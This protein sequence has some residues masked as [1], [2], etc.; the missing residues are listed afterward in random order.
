MC[1]KTLGRAIWKET[2]GIAI[3]KETLAVRM[4]ERTLRI[5]G[6]RGSAGA[7]EHRRT[8]RIAQ[9]EMESE[10]EMEMEMMVADMRCLAGGKKRT[11]RLLLTAIAAKV[12][13]ELQEATEA[14]ERRLIGGSSS[15]K[16]RSQKVAA[17]GATKG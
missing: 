6:R 2:L 15:R 17:V 10:T 12:A 7:A 9:V 3:C 13:K 8:P 4:C 11:I 16:K 5:I 14:L 1:Q